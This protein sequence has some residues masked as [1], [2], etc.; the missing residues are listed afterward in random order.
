MPGACGPRRRLLGR[1]SKFRFERA[2]HAARAT[3]ARLSLAIVPFGPITAV[4]HRAKADTFTR[5]SILFRPHTCRQKLFCPV[6]V[7]PPGTAPGSGPFIARAFIAIVPE[8][9]DHMWNLRPAMSSLG[10]DFATTDQLLLSECQSMQG[11]ADDSP[12][13]GTFHARPRFPGRQCL[14][15]LQQLYGNIVR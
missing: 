8:G 1:R 4:P 10:T 7:E 6:L 2:A 14:A 5:P 3:G 11:R 15:F 9:T 12:V 13:S